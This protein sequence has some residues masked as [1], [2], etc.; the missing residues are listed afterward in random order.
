MSKKRPDKIRTSR[1]TRTKTPNSIKNALELE[2]KKGYARDVIRELE[3]QG[4]TVPKHVKTLAE[5]PTPEKVTNKTLSQYKGATS[6]LSL[7]YISRH[8]YLTTNIVYGGGQPYNIEDTATRL[9]HYDIT[10]GTA[11]KTINEGLKTKVTFRNATGEKVSKHIMSDRESMFLSA[12]IYKATG[13]TSKQLKPGMEN[14]HFII[15]PDW[16]KKMTNLAS[17]IKF[18]KTST[19]PEAIQYLRELSS[20]AY[21]SSKLYSLYQEQSSYNRYMEYV[22]DAANTTEQGVADLYMEM[23]SHVL[24]TSHAWNVAKSNTID[25]NQTKSQ[26]KELLRIGSITQSTH[27]DNLIDEFV[28]MINNEVDFVIISQWFDKKVKNLTRS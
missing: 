15:S 8:S 22:N 12:Y 3:S 20:I 14:E 16:D 24:N 9:T 25:S 1:K 26:Y 17:N 2:R 27:K 7:A 19:N 28:S 21:S 11:Q 5:S 18:K 4:Y 6:P 10:H 13:L 23:L